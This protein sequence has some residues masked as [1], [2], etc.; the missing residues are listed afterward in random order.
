MLVAAISD[1]TI[2][3][4]SPQM[5]ALV[6]SVAEHFGAEA[7]MVEPAQPELPA[8]HSQ[9]PSFQF[10]R[11]ATTAHPHSPLGRAEY[12]W[13]GARALNR[14]RPDVLIVGCTYSLPVVFKLQRRPSLVLYYCLESIPFYGGFDVDL[15][16][17]LGDRVDV[18]IF[19][20]ENRAVREVMRCGFHGLAKVVM[21]NTTN[22][23]AA[24]A[25]IR[26][27]P[28][29]NG[30][31]LYGGTISR[32]QTF[33]DYFA[34]QRLSDFPIDLFGALRFKDT[35]DRSRFIEA[36]HGNV[37]YHGTLSA[38]RLA[39]RRGEYI[40]SI[41]AWNPTN[42]NQHFAA[43]NKFFESIAAGVPPI[44]APHPQCEEILRRY[45]CGILMPDWS[46]GAFRDTI[47]KA[48]AFYE[49]DAWDEMVANCVHAAQVELNWETQFSRLLPYLKLDK[50]G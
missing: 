17:H 25:L 39:A 50:R 24:P 48:L 28:M 22:R 42:E 45:R 3:Y 31:I 44:A 6:S 20:E 5:P 10:H 33:A 2:G 8:R 16:S 32:E 40:F 4:G 27:R 49:N 14:I 46:F 23:A 36:L 12:I 29:R 47:R 19:P 1:V 34:D 37:R 38:S 41:V 13:Q 30:R 11:I 7:C 43:P 15:N 35:G 21:L 26:P 9:F 18:A